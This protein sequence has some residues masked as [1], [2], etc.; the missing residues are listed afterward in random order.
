[1]PFESAL[2]ALVPEAESLVET[3]RNRYDPAAA[4]GVPAHVTILY[5]FKPPSEFTN[6]TMADLQELFA[7]TPS[8]PVSFSE[9]RRFPNV[10]YLAPNPAE[11]FQKLIKKIGVRFPET[12]P[13]GGAFAEVIPHLTIAQLDDDQRLNEIAADFNKA[14]KGK[15]PIRARI[16]TIALIN[17]LGGLWDVQTQFTLLQGKEAS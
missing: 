14:A 13:Y 12:P 11:P 7:T 8:F 17:N 10:L 15:L 9:T 6:D 5:P 1:M 16:D 4:I 3:F 2:V